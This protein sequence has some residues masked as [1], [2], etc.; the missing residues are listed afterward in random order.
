L[1]AVYADGHSANTTRA[2]LIAAAVVAVLALIVRIC[3]VQTFKTNDD[4]GM[5][6]ICSGHGY[7]SAPDEHLLYTNIVVGQMLAALYTFNRHCPWYGS[8][9]FIVNLVGMI[10]VISQLIARFKRTGAI[11]AVSI[12]IICV[13]FNNLILLQFTTAAFMVGLGGY[14]L[15]L[16]WLE[17][18][19]EVSW[20]ALVRPLL[21]IVLLIICSLVRYEIFV[22]VTILSMFVYAV[23]FLQPWSKLKTNWRT[24]LMI[25]CSIAITGGVAVAF[26][27]YNSWVYRQSS[28]WENFYQANRLMAGFSD[29]GDGRA[30]SELRKREA[31]IAAGWT[32][33]DLKIL[34]N[35]FIL[36][37]ELFSIEKMQTAVKVLKNSNYSSVVEVW[38]DFSPVFSN[39]MVVPIIVAS[40]TLMLTCTTLGVKKWR[41]FVLALL[42]LGL[43]LALL[44]T[45]KLPEHVFFP[46]FSFFLFVILFYCDLNSTSRFLSTPVKKIL[47]AIVC[48]TVGAFLV[49]SSYNNYIVRGQ[50]VSERNSL[51]KAAIHDLKP[52]STDLYL[53][54]RDFFPY[55]V[56]LPFDDLSEFFSEMKI[57][58]LA[59]RAD[60]SIAAKRM[61]E[62]DLTLENFGRKV[63]EKN[64]YLVSGDELNPFM[65]IYLKEHYALDAE[66][67]LYREY[68]PLRL[69][70]YQIEAVGSKKSQ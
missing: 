54:W 25:F 61:K 27:Q 35:V 13:C 65:K 56:I 14:A 48:L 34:Q 36:N 58:P 40:L 70:L 16:G 53:V 24:L 10:A 37:S 15:I 62:F 32:S 12:F 33:N 68:L 55:E 51:L 47:T 9:L 29:Y 44:L 49:Y 52:S 41:L 63:I 11:I 31:Q 19:L 22:L 43:M 64:V 4:V 39:A 66:L 50:R 57:L 30:A 46:I 20:P 7:T 59:Y 18:G 23:R 45:L 3:F 1:N 2:T 67:K 5:S 28:G 6:M 60:Y 17:D 69:R 26:Q 38:N 21:G 8:Y 42:I